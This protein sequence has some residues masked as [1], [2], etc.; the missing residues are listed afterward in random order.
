[1]TFAAFGL[2]LQGM[3]LVGTTGAAPYQLV[4]GTG[5]IFTFN[6]PADGQNHRMLLFGSNN[7]SV[8]ATGGA[9]ALT[10][11]PPGGVSAS[12][13]VCAGSKAVGQH[14]LDVPGNVML[15]PGSVVTLAQSTALTVGT[16]NANF[17]AWMI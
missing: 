6:V 9:I 8:A 2:S 13:T 10:F 7:V 14:G 3:Q 5:T 11:T 17:E 15:A 4:N 16:E 1:M 12:I